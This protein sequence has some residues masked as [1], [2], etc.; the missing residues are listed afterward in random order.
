ML[1]NETWWKYTLGA[2]IW[3]FVFASFALFLGGAGHGTLIFYVLAAS[4]VFNR[5][6][7]A[8]LATA[9]LF[10]SF[11]V[12]LSQVRVVR[13]PKLLIATLLGLHYA[14][15]VVGYIYIYPDEFYFFGEE[16]PFISDPGLILASLSVVALAI[17]VL[18]QVV[19][20]RKL[21]HAERSI[22]VSAVGGHGL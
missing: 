12:L 14:G 4:P 2:I 20:Y 17:Y 6:A 5:S 9:P 1:L 16:G 11:L 21:L 15:A 3:G 7:V 13:W 18:G 19:F 10:W 8:A 22:K